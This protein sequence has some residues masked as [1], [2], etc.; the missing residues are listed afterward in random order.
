MISRAMDLRGIRA[1]EFAAQWGGGELALLLD[2]CF[3]R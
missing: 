2:D 1:V 3:P